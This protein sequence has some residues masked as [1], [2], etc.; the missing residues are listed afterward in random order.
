MD[1]LR[2]TF[3]DEFRTH[4]IEQ[5][6]NFREFSGHIQ[7]QINAHT[8]ATDTKISVLDDRVKELEDAPPA[9]LELP[10]A[11]IFEMQKLW[12]TE[13]ALIEAFTKGALILSNL[14]DARGQPMAELARKTLLDQLFANLKIKP[15]KVEHIITDGK[16]TQFTRLV[17]K[18]EAE[19]KQLMTKW[20]D[21]IKAGTKVVNGKKAPIYVR[22][23]LPPLVRKLREPMIK[24]ERQLKAFHRDQ[25]TKH[26]IRIVWFLHVIQSDGQAVAKRRSD[27]T[28]NWLDKELGTSV[29]NHWN[30]ITTGQG[31]GAS[32]E[33]KEV[34]PGKSD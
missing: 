18:D 21:A 16:I 31:G 15:Q 24:A 22:S 6:Q 19:A 30:Q 32:G 14:F 12:A 1:R 26:K 4:K 28:V 25:N 17:F 3:L 23:D 7:S 29:I 2:S 10:T 13:T 8:T 27:G 33:P 34:T 11:E 20:M 9:Y 5:A